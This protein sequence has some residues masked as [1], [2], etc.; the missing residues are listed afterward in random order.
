MHSF[1]EIHCKDILQN[2]EFLKLKEKEH[3][4]TSNV[5]NHSVRVASQCAKFCEKLKIDSQKT[6]D[7]LRAALLH[8]FYDFDRK[9][10]HL[11]RKA[12]KMPIIKRMKTC[13]L[14]AHPASAA[15]H[16]KKIFDIN[17]KQMSAIRSH[18][19]PFSPLPKSGGAWLIIA[20]DKWV[21]IKELIEVIRKKNIFK[22]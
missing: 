20:S 3:H 11:E 16:A 14:F 18:M 5:Y 22:W 2:P 17:E 12:A 9:K 15:Q 4:Y 6:H 10:R 19:F 1:L 7:T 21:T 13:F 8:D